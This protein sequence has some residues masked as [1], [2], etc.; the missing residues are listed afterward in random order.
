[1]NSTETLAKQVFGKDYGDVVRIKPFKSSA[2]GNGKQVDWRTLAES[3]D[4]GGY[5]AQDDIGWHFQ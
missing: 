2:N 1:M 3:L 4:E 5:N